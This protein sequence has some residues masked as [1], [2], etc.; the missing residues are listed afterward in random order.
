MDEA[1]GT[2]FALWLMPEGWVEK[3]LL[4]WI[5]RLALRFRTPAF[6]PH[7]TLLSGL[8]A[9]EPDVL[10]AAARAASSLEPFTIHVDAVDGSDEHFRCLFV[11]VQEPAAVVAAHAAAARAFGREPDA[12]FRPHLSL[13]YGR[14]EPGTKLAAAHEVGSE[15]DVRFE[16]RRLHVWRTEGPVPEWREVG[17]FD[18]GS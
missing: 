11:Q 2:G 7:V 9:T 18:L 15:V 3:R 14:L 12:G 4:G 17:R 5:E 13:V 8:T 1:A 10:A 16:A 6:A